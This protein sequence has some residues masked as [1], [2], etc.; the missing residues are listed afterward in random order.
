MDAE[1]LKQQAAQAAIKYVEYDGVIGVGTGSTVSYFI[2][3]LAKIKGKVYGAVSSSKATTEKLKAVGIPIIDLNV[4]SEVPFY[5]DGADEINHHLQ[6]IKGGGGALTS[7][8]IVASCAK[9]V[10]CLA[11]ESKRVDLLGQHPVAIEVLPEARSAVGR[12]I[13]KLKGDPMYRENF[14]T[15]HDNL[16]IDVYNLDLTDPLFL[17][18]E[19]NNIPGVVANGIFAQRPADLLILAR[20]SG[21]KELKAG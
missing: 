20:E 17:E 11:D 12:A 2:D 21:V 19:I 7:E 4:V 3:E 18:A 16:I 15:D 9:T 1:T 14:V 13:V 8:K 10:V 5:F 6:M